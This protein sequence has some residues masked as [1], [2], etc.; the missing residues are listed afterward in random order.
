VA[1]PNKSHLNLTLWAN[2]RVFGQIFF[3]ALL[4]IP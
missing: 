2:Q 4:F 1:L 3:M